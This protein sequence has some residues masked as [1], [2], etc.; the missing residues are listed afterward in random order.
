MRELQLADCEHGVEEAFAEITELASRCRFSDC[1]HQQEPGCAVREA[2]ESD[3][4]EQRRL[5]SYQKLMR[6]QA[7]NKATLAERRAQ[8]REFGRHVRSVIKGKQGE[9]GR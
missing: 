6:E 5:A 3:E 2:I 8:E 1:Q 9:K 7:F 4:L